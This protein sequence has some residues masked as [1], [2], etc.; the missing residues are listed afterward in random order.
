M[1]KLI[2]QS[3]LCLSCFAAVAATAQTAVTVISPAANA[4]PKFGGTPG[5]LANSS[6]SD[7]NG[8]VIMEATNLHLGGFI[9]ALTNPGLYTLSQLDGASSLVG[10]TGMGTVFSGDLI[11]RNYFGVSIDINNGG[12]GDISGSIE[13]RIP[14]SSSFTVNSRNSPTSFQTLF[15]VRNNG[16]VGVGTTAPGAKLEVNGNL[17]LTSGSGASM[18]FSDGTI[19]NTAW[20]GSL[21]GGDYAEAMDVSGDR[22]K[23]EPGDVLELDPSLPGNVVKVAEPYS[24]MVA[25]IYSTKPGVL[26]RRQTTDPKVSTTEVPMAMVGVVPTK[27]SSENGPIKVGDLL[28]TSSTPGH[29][30]KGTDRGLMLGAIVG[31]AMGNLDSGRGV[32]EVLVTLQ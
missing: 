23:Y 15:T 4:I 6:I 16:N 13:T 5:T 3:V 20:T 28:V 24:Q 32:I 2:R 22:T 26:G 27:V 9:N 31:K 10:N 1:Q 7:A 12:Q 29:A 18:T 11:L 30:M 19:Q 8:V 25:G 21:C 17:K 14:H